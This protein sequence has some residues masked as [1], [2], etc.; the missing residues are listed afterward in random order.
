MK[1]R[2]APFAAP[3][4]IAAALALS[5]CGDDDS[6]TSEAEQTS[7]PETAIAEIGET[8]KGLNEALATY[9]KG[10]EAGAADQVTETYLQHFELVEPP[11]EEVDEE[12]TEELEEAIREE[13]V[14]AMEAGDPVADVTALVKQIDA[15]LGEAAK[16]LQGS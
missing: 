12:L 5:A 9:E 14:S 13:L 7:S 2:N 11:L 6:T 16:A 4:L 1:L 15:D 10:D 8:E 3:A